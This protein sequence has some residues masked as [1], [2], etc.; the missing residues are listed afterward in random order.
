MKS[1]LF[2]LFVSIFL[3]PSSAQ[4]IK[5][6]LSDSSYSR[7]IEAD[8]D[9]LKGYTLFDDD[10]LMHLSLT[11][12]IT[13]FIR[14]KMKGEYLDV[15]MEITY[16]EF[17][18]KKEIRLKAR[19][20]NRREQCFF[21]PIYL[22]FK[23]DPIEHSELE[24]M[25]KVKLV[26]HCKN[27]KAYQEYILKEYLI[28]KLY[29][30]LSDYSFRVKLLDIEYND[31]GKRNRNY[32]QY[33]FLIEPIDLLAKRTNAIEVKPKVSPSSVV[34][35]FDTDVAALFQYMIGN[36]D[37]RIQVGHNTKF[38]KSLDVLSTYL[39]P[40]SYDFDFA[41]FVGASYA[42]PQEWTSIQSIYEREYLGYCRGDEEYLKVISH[43]L[44]HKDELNS[45]IASFSYLSEKSR[46]E[47]LSYL[48]PFFKM[49][50][51]EEWIL[52]TLKNE[53]RELTF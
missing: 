48:A 26:T 25:K 36:T 42:F 9:T 1:L 35:P 30:V 39:I 41:G 46:A 49:L 28:Y 44:N 7:S 32:S 17:Y 20:N 31:T 22:N 5:S 52:N 53:C 27:S 13:S 18:K 43:F 45:T 3:L 19:G 15:E 47:L 51:D 50:E 23:T 37:W 21:P 4:E 38:V 12:D 2:L 29:N 40:V 33:G 14:K 8:R 11:F 16:N 10:E 24:G 34:D 6:A